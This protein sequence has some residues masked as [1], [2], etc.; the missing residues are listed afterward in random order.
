MHAF[1]H[2]ILGNRDCTKYSILDSAIFLESRSNEKATWNGSWKLK[3]VIKCE[4]VV[5]CVTLGGDLYLI[6]RS[7]LHPNHQI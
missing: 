7:D 2:C 5:I 3:L 4:A 1:H 6:C